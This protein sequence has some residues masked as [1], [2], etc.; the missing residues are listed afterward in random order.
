V[1]SNTK[2]PT[3]TDDFLI[4]YE[5]AKD[6]FTKKDIHPSFSKKRYEPPL[7][8]LPHIERKIE[9]LKEQCKRNNLVF[10][11]DRIAR[12]DDWKVENHNLYL[13]F[14][15]TTYFHFAAMNLQVN[16]KFN[17]QGT[18]KRLK[19]ILGENIQD[20]RQS[21]LPNAFGVNISIILKKES[22]IALVRR[23]NKSF[24]SSAVLSS[25]VAGTVS[26][27]Q[28]DLDAFGNPDPLKAA[29]RE[30]LEELGISI[31]MDRIAIHGIG[32]NKLN[33][34]PEI[35][36]E[37]EVDMTEGQLRTSWQ[38]ATDRWE[39]PDLLFLD[40]NHQ[41]LEPLLKNEN[42]NPISKVSTLASLNA[43]DSIN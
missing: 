25:A 3:S 18:K 34:K 20:L 7:E 43:R 2:L 37:F 1:T 31:D 8:L 19:D 32:R 29:S 33:F 24:E 39:S 26:I 35:Y 11:D 10:F 23:S 38:R 22:K 27:G 14:S 17:H 4:L 13:D 16:E 9:E 36:G 42:W 5:S 40:L 28:G 12:L 30:A 15:E 41:E 6:P 21:R